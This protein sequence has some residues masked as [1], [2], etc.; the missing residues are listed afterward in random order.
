MVCP[1][2]VTA[3]VPVGS[4]TAMLFDAMQKKLLAEGK[5]GPEW[6]EPSRPRCGEAD[7]VNQLCG[8]AELTGATVYIV[9]IYTL[10]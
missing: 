9:H 8:V 4:T 6:H 10:T 2:H 3:T 7:G 1:P 5:T